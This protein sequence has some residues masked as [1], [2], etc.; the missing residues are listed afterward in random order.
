MPIANSLFVSLSCKSQNL[1]CAAFGRNVGHN[2]AR[3]V[4]RNV[5]R[6]LGLIVAH[7]V[8]RNVG[9]N[10]GRSIK[11]NVERNYGRSFERN[12]GR[13]FGHNL[14]CLPETDLVRC[15]SR[16]GIWVL[17]ATSDGSPDAGL[18]HGSQ[19]RSAPAT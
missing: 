12:V 6:K 14:G 5:G 3:N 9:C 1:D 4:D 7:S 16:M 18:V 2:V 15:S 13:S 19:S 11:R 8:S 10:V 17:N